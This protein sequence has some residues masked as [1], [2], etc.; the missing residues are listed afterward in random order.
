[1]TI[2]CIC[3]IAPV[4]SSFIAYCKFI[5]R[6]SVC[7][8]R[9]LGLHKALVKAPVLFR[10]LKE[11][12]IFV[13]EKIW[14]E[15]ILRILAGTAR[16]AVTWFSQNSCLKIQNFAI[17]GQLWQALFPDLCMQ[18]AWFIYHFKERN[19]SF[20][21]HAHTWSHLLC[22]AHQSCEMLKFRRT[23][24]AKEYKSIQHHPNALLI[25]DL[26]SWDNLK[27]FF[28]TTFLT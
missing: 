14:K 5:T 26:K 1:M 12:R 11:W 20:L 25:N 19:S 7:R 18:S 24:H 13:G 17:I 23:F 22:N 15:K 21:N 6:H 10:W 27:Q 2:E 9:L 8:G 3:D 28:G 16:I 4:R